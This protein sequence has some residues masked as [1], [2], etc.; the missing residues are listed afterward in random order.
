MR[1]SLSFYL[2]F[3]I[4]E[5]NITLALDE[6][7]KWLTTPSECAMKMSTAGHLFIR[8]VLIDPLSTQNISKMPDKV[9]LHIFSY[10]EH[11]EICRLATICKKWRQIAYDTRLWANVS[12]RPEV[13]GL[14]VQSHDSLINLVR[15]ENSYNWNRVAMQPL[16]TLMPSQLHITY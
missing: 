10:L 2:S 8:R 1:V 7:T 12:L 14:H 3:S 4:F 15:W 6:P 13:S 11:R 9:L 16:C 5:N